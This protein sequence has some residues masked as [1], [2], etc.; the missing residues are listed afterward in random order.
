MSSSLEQ[1]YAGR[2]RD[3]WSRSALFLRVRGGATALPRCTGHQLTGDLTRG[4]HAART[5]HGDA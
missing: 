5:R 2:L 1:V 4:D 3:F